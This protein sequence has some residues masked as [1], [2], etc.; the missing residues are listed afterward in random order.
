MKTKRLAVRR[1]SKKKQAPPPYAIL[2]KECVTQMK[3]V[4][5]PEDSAWS[6][7]ENLIAVTKEE[8][9]SD[10]SDTLCR[11]DYTFRFTKGN[12]TFE[13]Y[14]LYHER[15]KFKEDKESDEEQDAASDDEEWEINRTGLFLS[16]VREVPMAVCDRALKVGRQEGEDS[17]SFEDDELEDLS[18]NHLQWPFELPPH[19]Y[20]GGMQD[21]LKARNN[22]PWP[23]VFYLSEPKYH[24]DDNLWVAADPERD[25][26]SPY[27]VG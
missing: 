9:V 15:Q 11:V 18:I 10:P 23:M 12:E 7:K 16:P 14:V 21:E 19:R 17:F 13:G 26:Y 22:K 8:S 3:H 5:N 27:F 6:L 4:Y 24:P 2:P 1:R 25:Q 20:N